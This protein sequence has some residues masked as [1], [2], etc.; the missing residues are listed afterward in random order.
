MPVAVDK[1][2]GPVLHLHKEFVDMKEPDGF[3]NRTDTTITFNDTSRLFTLA[4]TGSSFSY[5]RQ[6]KKVTKT[7]SQTV[8]IGDT[9]GT[10]YIYFDS[11]DTLVSSTTEWGYGTNQVFVATI[12]WRA[13]G[14]DYLFGDERHGIAM[15]WS[16][17]E[18]LHD[19]VGT[20]YQ[21]GLTGT[22]NDNNTFTITAGKIHDE[23]IEHSISQQTTVRILYRD[24]VTGTWLFDAP[25]TDYFKETADIIQ[26]DNNGVLTDVPNGQYVSYYAFAT[27]DT[28]DP[29]YMIVGQR[30]DTNIA[31]A[32][33]NQSIGSISLANLPSREMKPIWQ[34]I[35]KRAGLGETVERTVDLRLI[36][37]LSS[38]NFIAQDHGSLGG[39]DDDDHAQYALLAGRSGG[40]V[41]YGGTAASDDLE[42]DSTSNATKGRILFNSGAAFVDDA[43]ELVIGRQVSCAPT[44]HGVVYGCKIAT[45]DEGANLAS[46]CSS[47]ST[48][49]A[50]VAPVK[51]FLRTRNT[52]D[53]PT[54]VQSGDNLMILSASGWDG[55]DFEEAARIIAQV[56]GAPG[57]NDMP[58]KL[59]FQVTP[60][61][62]FSP[63]TALSISQNTNINAAGNAIIGSTTKVPEDKL[64][65]YESGSVVASGLASEGM[66]IQYSGATANSTHIIMMSG[67]TGTSTIFFGD[68]AAYSDAS[69]QYSA[70]TQEVTLGVSTSNC[71]IVKETTTNTSDSQT[72][73][74]VRRDIP[75]SAMSGTFATGIRI[76]AEDTDALHTWVD[77][78]AFRD[79]ADNSALFNLNVANAGTMHTLIAASGPDR[80]VAIGPGVTTTTD[81][82]SLLKVDVGALDKRSGYFARNQ[83]AA[84]Y[85]VLDVVQDHTTAGQP[86]IRIQQDDVSEG[87]TDY[88]G[89][90]RGAIDI[91]AV[92]IM[93]TASIRV[94]LNGTVYT[95]PLFADQ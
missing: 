6:G 16:T 8:T 26:Y 79:D 42:L 10:H 88:I 18:T 31:N 22:F 49:T 90:D 75:A 14:S 85:A 62:G 69:L 71:F 89:S 25:S 39:L 37:T 61:G 38:G 36:T 78:W 53:S 9:T 52:H 1:I 70:N 67:A 23:D 95:I 91:G 21:S 58:G 19:T 94:E 27:N 32:I 40:Q 15:D 51:L 17:H 60:D 80:A 74:V 57:N 63:A 64:H 5:Y 33:A 12:Y 47:S 55:T 20:T 84:S 83:S 59:L 3:P 73:L 68:E 34:V 48:D 81:P 44:V 43:D 30:V 13:G 76:Q 7:S 72:P 50:A 87:F 66:R 2:W 24:G 65:L 4:P 92:G 45:I 35:L 41:L 93:S 86:G 28:N 46:V 29:I 77:M 82:N 54:A 56:D 11:T